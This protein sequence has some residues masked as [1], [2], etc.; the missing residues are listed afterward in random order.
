MKIIHKM[1]IAPITAIVCL[2]LIGAL[3]L[4]AMQGQDKRMLELNDVTFSAFRSA[5]AQTIAL[6]QIHAE[7]YAKIAIMASLDE[8][9]VKLFNQQLEQ[10][11][12]GV[13]AEFSKMQS[14]PALSTM[15]ERSKPILGRYKKTVLAAV[16]MASMDPNT[17]IASMQN[18][19]AE[20]QALRAELDAT[21]K[22][23]DAKTTQAMQESKSAN[24]Q[25]L[26]SIG[27]TLTLALLALSG[28]SIWVAR[29]VTRPLNQAV[30]IAQNVA[31]GQFSST[32]DTSQTD[33][34]GDLMR[35]LAEMVAQLA[36]IDRKM[37]GEVLIQQTAIASASANIMIADP[38]GNVIYLN[39]S[40]TELLQDA[41]LDIA[42]E[43]AQFDASKVLGQP[44]SAFGKGP[45]LAEL[46]SS[47]QTN[48]ELGPRIFG[49]IATP[50]FDA[51][52][53]RLGSVIEWKDRT[54]EVQEARQ[55]RDNARIRQALDNC[56]TNIMIA[57]AEGKINYVNQSILA[58]FSAAQ[59]EIR[60]QMGQFDAHALLGSNVEL[61]YQAGKQA[62]SL[63]NLQTTHSTE[64][65]LGG[66]IFA[67]SA[68]P[69]F[70]AQNHRLGTVVE[71]HD[72]TIEIATETEVSA[73]VNGASLG[74]FSQRIAEE[75]KQGFFASLAL[76]MNKLMDTSERGLNDVVRMLAALADGDLSQSITADYA[77]TFGRLKDDANTTC[78]KLA[79]MIA[80]VRTAASALTAASNQVSATAHSL[81]LSASDQASG[82]ERT[83]NSVDMM[84]GSVTQNN[85]NA[86]ITDDMA[87][88]SAQEA[89]QGGD[90]VTQTVAAMK[91]IATKISIVDDIA[92]QTNLL[93]LNAAIEAARAGQHGKGF[94]VVAAEVRKLAERS[95]LAAKDIG[96]LAVS[97]VT[98]SEQAGQVLSAMI[99]SIRK[100]SQLVQEISL[101]SQSQAGSLADVSAA[102]GQLNQSTQQNAAAAEELAATAEEMSG[103]AEQLQDLMD[104]FKL[105]EASD[106]RQAGRSP[107]LP[108]SKPAAA[109][110]PAVKAV[111]GT[112]PVAQLPGL[113]DES[114]FKK[115]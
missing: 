92:Y 35:A 89:V 82:F 11:I 79:A 6:G 101:A 70:D 57:N 24:Q 93:A 78:E 80:N 113:P 47:V 41:Q 95:Q 77:G 114:L 14:N 58:M 49:L 104:I 33:E 27:L 46:S 10:K 3:S 45:Q 21:V 84:S 75:G 28:I 13:L 39:A 42:S 90:A 12:D 62:I 29:N 4:L 30:E 48:L 26:I 44:F 66:H 98:V 1:F 76:S 71:W 85:E 2:A 18:A 60:Q 34:I 61:F 102:M 115:F 22:Q 31:S 8:K 86:R 108:S 83:S 99:P 19:N 51:A 23:L 103:Q 7:V 63:H 112:R 73:V 53:N 9:A 81:A 107:E 106:R 68:S 55:A 15:L 100:T 50:I 94:A 43:I 67:L 40:M 32:V 88:K 56:T 65:T 37:K 97:S 105:S 96:E 110:K 17:G 59:N 54:L 25:M 5:S 87:A 20:Y 16:D 111:R 109:A 52:Q 74:D 36:R 69:V 38:T 64:I 91:Q 72:R